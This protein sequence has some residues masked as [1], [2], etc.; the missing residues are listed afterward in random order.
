MRRNTTARNLLSR[1]LPIVFLVAIATAAGAAEPTDAS[2]KL[3]A[4]LPIADMHYHV[5]PHLTPR[6]LTAQMDRN[7]VRWAGGVGPVWVG[8]PVDA[9]IDR[10]GARY[11]GMAGQP[12]FLMMLRSVGAK[13]LGDAGNPIFTAM[14]TRAEQ[15]FAAGRIHGFGELFLNNMNSSPDVSFRRKTSAESA[16]VQRMF[17]LAARFSGVIQVHMEPEQASVDALEAVMARYPDV[18][19]IL[20]HCMATTASPSFPESFLRAHPRTY[21][22]L[23]AR[24]EPVMSSFSRQLMIYGATFADERWVKLMEALPDR[25]T[26]GSDLTD[27]SLTYD[28]II[29]NMRSGLLPRLS[30]PTARKIAYENAM[31]LFKLP[32]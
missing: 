2:R 30:A 6:D 15:D 31:K 11:V 27:S 16:T 7:N 29:A 5:V 20:S 3:A 26:L 12:D 14:M 10:M 23:S 17:A 18:P 21:C 13:G 24:A 32:M 1:L 19:V 4:E 22:D 28:K 8:L 25:F 9:F